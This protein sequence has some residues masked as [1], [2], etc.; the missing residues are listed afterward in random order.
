MKI[1]VASVLLFLNLLSECHLRASLASPT[2]WMGDSAAEQDVLAQLLLDEVADVRDG[3]TRVIVVGDA[4]LWGTLRDLER[5]A[6]PYSGAPENPGILT[7]TAERKD[8]HQEPN[9]SLSVL[10]R[11]TMR[12]MV[13]RVYRPCWEVTSVAGSLT[14]VYYGKQRFNKIMVGMGH[15]AVSRYHGGSTRTLCQRGM[16]EVYVYEGTL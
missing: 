3:A 16:G 10:R 4:S 2:G 9:P 5:G 6:L 7:T 11:D 15:A 14:G 13:G 1:S 8:G 12:C